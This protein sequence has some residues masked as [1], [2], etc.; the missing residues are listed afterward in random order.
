MNAGPANLP[1]LINRRLNNHRHLQEPVN[2]R[3]VR[4]LKVLKMSRHLQPH[5]QRPN[6]PPSPRKRTHGRKR[7]R[8]IQTLGSLNHGHPHRSGEKVI[9][10]LNQTLRWTRGSVLEVDIPLT[11]IDSI[12]RILAGSTTETRQFRISRGYSYRWNEKAGISSNQ[13]LAA[14]HAQ[15]SESL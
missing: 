14:S 15:S 8:S 5:P 6:L 10:T 13:R 11:K 9:H 2:H 1:F 12:S 7:T 4:L 3:R